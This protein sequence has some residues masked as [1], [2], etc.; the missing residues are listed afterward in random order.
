MVVSA[1]QYLSL[2]SITY[3]YIVF[4]CFLLILTLALN[5]KGFVGKG[6]EK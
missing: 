1:T 4:S 2:K 5:R 6:M 3:L